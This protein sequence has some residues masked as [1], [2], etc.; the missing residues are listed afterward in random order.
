MTIVA[1]QTAPLVSVINNTGGKVTLP[2]TSGTTTTST[3]GDPESATYQFIAGWILFIIILVFANK[4]RLGHVIIYYSLILIILL[5]L[6]IE[7]SE[8]VPL[9]NS[10]Q[11]IGQFNQTS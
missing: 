1:S 5:L 8:V 6:L 11:T 9:L 3:S 2:T 4:T 10:V 7:Y